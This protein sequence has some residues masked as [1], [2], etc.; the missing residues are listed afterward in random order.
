MT[1]QR[2]AGLALLALGA[3][4]LFAGCT[5]GTTRSYRQSE[6]RTYAIVAVDRDGILSQ[7]QLSKIQRT[8]VHYLMQAGWVQGDQTLIDDVFKAGVVFRVKISWVADTGAFAVNEVAPTYGAGPAETE[9][10]E[11]TTPD[12]GPYG[13]DQ[14]WA[15]D[16]WLNDPWGYDGYYSGYWCGPYL[17]FLPASFGFFEY[18][19]HRPPAIANHPRPTVPIPWHPTATRHDYAHYVPPPYRPDHAPRRPP[20]HR[21]AVTPED[22]ASS[23]PLSMATR[24]R[25]SVPG[26]RDEPA[27]ANTPASPVSARDAGP[28]PA[29]SPAS[30][31][32]DNSNS[33]GST[34]RP[35][36]ASTNAS[37]T[38]PADHSPPP[39]R[40]NRPTPSRDSG[41]S[42]A[43]RETSSAHPRNASPD[44]RSPPPASAPGMGSHER[45]SPPPPP[46]A[47][48]SPSSSHSTPSS[49]RDTGP[50]TQER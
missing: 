8:I 29:R 1:I 12:Y 26:H 44:Y 20:L 39:D 40:S 27:S 7:V 49:N 41:G 3:V 2:P 21:A 45:S 11:E 35:S 13:P 25:Y 17:P 22:S 42:T 9:Y 43:P 16:P 50:V 24:P 34:N 48:S 18:R 30:W 33:S 37:G 38:K 47:S 19:H 4:L 36:A 23:S 5:S 31:R 46:P 6:P 15:G 10:A 32:H 28:Q 14:R